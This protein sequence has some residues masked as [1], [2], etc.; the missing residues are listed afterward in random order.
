MSLNPFFL[1]GSPGEQRLV[2]D[3]INEQLKIYGIEVTYIPRKFVRKQTILEEIQS[4]KFDDNF[5][6]EAYLSNY[7]GYSG[8]GDILTKFGMSLRDEMSLVISRERFEDF[9]SPFLDAMDHDE[10]EL[11]SRPREGDLIY[12][13]LGQ[14]LFEVKFVEH[15]QPFY[16]LGKNYVYELKCELFEYE[17]EVLD[18]S[19][20]EI[21]EVL[22]NQGEII[23]LKLFSFGQTASANSNI[24]FGY[25]RKVYINNDGSGYNSTPS[26]SITPAPSGGTNATA[27][28][29]TT[30]IAGVRSLKEIVL[31]NAGAGYTVAPTITISG[32]GGIGA[33]A[34]CEIQIHQRGVI[35]IPI[36]DGGNGYATPPLVTIG[37]PTI[38]APSAVSFL[39]N[40]IVDRVSITN[41]GSSFSPKANISVIFSP[42]NSQGFSTSTASGIVAND[43][44]SKI[45]VINPGIGYSQAPSVSISSPT[46][47]AITATANS[48][49][50]NE[51]VS[52]ISIANSGR[53]YITNPII[54]VSNPVGV[55]STALATVSLQTGGIS[56]ISASIISSGRYYLTAPNLIVNYLQ[57]PPSYVNN[58]KFGN[59]AFKL[60]S[61]VSDTPVSY[62]SSLG[63]VSIGSSGFFQFWAKVPSTLSVAT[64]AISLNN[65]SNGPNARNIDFRITSS[66]YAEVGIGTTASRISTDIRDN[67]WHYFSIIST[68]SSSQRVSLYM[69]G[70]SEND[71]NFTASDPEFDLVSNVDVTPPILRNSTNSGI[72]I[73]DIYSSAIDINGSSNIP[74]GTP[75]I[76]D[77]DVILFDDFE[78]G[79]G[80]L[81]TISFG[82]TISNGLVTSLTSNSVSLSGV[83]TAISSYQFD[84]PAGSP[85]NFRATAS[86]SVSSGVVTSISITYGGYGY[87]QIP[88]ITVS[89][90]TG[91]ATQFTATAIANVSGVGTISGFTIT[92]SGLGYTQSPTITIGNPLGKTAEGRAIVG[93]SGTITS[94]LI[95]NSG[96]GYT[97]APTVSIANTIS[98]RDFLIGFSTATARSI[99]NDNTNQVISIQITDTG[100]GYQSSPSITIAP[101][102]S[103]SGVGTYW[104]NEVVVGSISGTKARVK[105][106]DADT[107][108][109]QI[110]IE[111]GTFYPGEL[112]VGAA[113]SAIYSI[114]GYLNKL[115]VST[116]EGKD[117]YEQ[118]DIIELEADQIIDFSEQN[119]FGNY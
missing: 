65:T 89:N 17:N 68:Y 75:P 58:S 84:A 12:F 90:P 72:I 112:L 50:N 79:I 67:E 70:S 11:A 42:P 43:Q 38:I 76:V 116:P 29:I 52:N 13:P 86:A 14:R 59:Y 108:I 62:A 73:D 97:V 32:G 80:N 40:S 46:G 87:L 48:S 6:L 85:S 107:G 118:N 21:D 39:N 71:M 47:Y 23:S 88:T 4:S 41:G 66:G 81:N 119:L 55:A 27:V 9:I 63:T 96:L 30:S 57:L 53:Y 10:I 19:V 61:E 5:L 99:I 20:G 56:T 104:F 113:S 115:D 3:L 106:W 18:T 109:M 83:I 117:D 51:Q 94:I 114:D 33:A 28:A 82:S 1:Q 102:P 92:N 36:V 69:D 93:S 77:D 111:D 7:D 100:A 16:Q 2:Q 25:I 74:T 64:T 54:T 110:S 49:I 45:E 78:S 34:T 22:Q 60:T 91:V 35:Q 98:D 15:E 105:R 24:G 26:I 95:T 101:P 8:A 103:I 44:I 37:S 31:T